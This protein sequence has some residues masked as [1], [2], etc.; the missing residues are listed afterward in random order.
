MHT[1][2]LTEA[3]THLCKIIRP[4]E[5][6]E[7]VTLTKRGKVVTKFTIADEAAVIRTSK[8]KK[9]RH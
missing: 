3:R 4:V 7:L 5:H 1:V 2:N 8:N 9:T 6:G